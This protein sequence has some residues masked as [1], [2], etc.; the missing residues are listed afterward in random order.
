MFAQLQKSNREKV[1]SLQDVKTTQVGQKKI[2]EFL[3]YLSDLPLYQINHEIDFLLSQVDLSTFDREAFWKI[4][5][6][7][8]LLEN[9][10]SPGA[11]RLIRKIRG[12]VYDRVKSMYHLS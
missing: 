5:A 9:R 4:D 7:M 1:V 3:N 11:A 2:Q 12:E 10:S 6:I 8:N